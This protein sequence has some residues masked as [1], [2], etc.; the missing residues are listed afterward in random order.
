MHP[1][2][3]G[4]TVIGTSWAYWK[5]VLT[6]TVTVEKDEVSPGSRQG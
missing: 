6:I 4:K 2:L 5:N 1:E 3:G